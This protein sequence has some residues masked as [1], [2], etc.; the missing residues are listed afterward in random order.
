M[1]QILFFLLVAL[2]VL[3]NAQKGGKPV[4]GGLTKGKG[5]PIG[6]VGPILTKGKVGPP[7]K[8]VNGGGLTGGIGSTGILGS[9]GLGSTGL[10]S[11]GLGSTGYTGS[12][13]STGTGGP[14]VGTLCMASWG[15]NAAGTLLSSTLITTYAPYSTF[16]QV[17]QKAFATNAF[18]Y[19]LVQDAVDTLQAL[20]TQSITITFTPTLTTDPLL[21]ILNW[22][23]GTYIF[24][25]PFTI[26]S[27]SG[28]YTYTQLATAVYQL[29]VHQ[30]LSGIFR[31]DRAVAGITWTPTP[32]QQTVQEIYFTINFTIGTYSL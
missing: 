4:P 17:V 14:G 30:T 10:G 23:P 21:F 18:A 3:I 15:T 8:P 9:T 16:D 29:I 6:K 19:A 31:F 7:T 22:T 25:V 32:V 20:A 24:S 28:V 5:G 12:T 13:G 2:L 11:T 1:K 26:E 27:Y